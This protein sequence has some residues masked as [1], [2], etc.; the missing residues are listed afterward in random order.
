MF[1]TTMTCVISSANVCRVQYAVKTDDER[2][3][4][5]LEGYHRELLTNNTK[6]SKRLYSDHGIQMRCVHT[7]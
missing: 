6:I 7:N 1:Y 4:A 5:A 3:V 2:L